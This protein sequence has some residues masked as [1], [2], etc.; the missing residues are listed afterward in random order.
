MQ[1]SMLGNPSA[2]F[3][4]LLMHHADLASGAAKAD[5]TQF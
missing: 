5:K 3:Y 2:F 4:Q 1:E